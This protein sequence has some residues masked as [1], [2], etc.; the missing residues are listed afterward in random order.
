MSNVYRY[1]QTCDSHSNN[2]LKKSQSILVLL[3]YIIDVCA[4]QTTIRHYLRE[5]HANRFQIRNIVF[6]FSP[7]FIITVPFPFLLDFSG[8]F[9]YVAWSKSRTVLTITSYINVAYII[10][11]LTWVQ[12]FRVIWY[13]SALKK[14]NSLPIKMYNFVNQKI[15]SLASSRE[16]E[17]Y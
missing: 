8:D 7:Y 1:W 14:C 15:K 16:C 13:N 4:L 9:S 11:I 2:T 5:G 17:L 3:Q 10:Y 12:E 6:S